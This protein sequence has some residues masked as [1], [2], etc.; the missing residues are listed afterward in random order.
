MID[1]DEEA[2]MTHLMIERTNH[3]FRGGPVRRWSLLAPVLLLVLAGCP[4]RYGTAA[5]GART[6]EAAVAQFLAGARAQDLQAMSAVFGDEVGP[7]RDR[8]DRTQMEQRLIIMACHLRHDESRIAAAQPGE[9]GR[10]LHRVEL[11]QGEKKASPVFTTT[12][13]A[14]SGQW[15]CSG[16]RNP[17]PP[18]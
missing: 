14:K 6:S 5:T 3:P 2:E 12:R 17:T 4:S 1:V 9:S 15:F 8:E 7:L 13:N 10:M 11:R 16:T 18:R